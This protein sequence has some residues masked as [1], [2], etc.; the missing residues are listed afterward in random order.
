MPTLIFPVDLDGL[1]LPVLIGLNGN[2]TAARAAAAQP[3]P[4]PVSVNAIVD[5]G[6]NV[7]CVSQV[8]L[9]RLAVAASGQAT[10]NTA[11]GEA[12]VQLYEVSMSVPGQG[13]APL[14]IVSTNLTVMELPGSVP[15]VD[16]LVGLDVLLRYK[17]LLDG[18]AKQYTLEV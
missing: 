17:L 11:A 7:T 1:L 15:G 16:V 8:V 13:N 5:T 14:T 4:L 18:P 10:T 2:E 12:V 9:S 6:T 3:I